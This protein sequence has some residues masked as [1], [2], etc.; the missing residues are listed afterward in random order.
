MGNGRFNHV[1]NS[2]KPVLLD[3]YADW[4]TPCKLQEPVLK[5]L[6][7]D[8]KDAVR[9]LKVDVNKN[10]LIATRYNIRSIPTIMIFK[11][12]S[13][14]WTGRGLKSKDELIQVLKKI[15]V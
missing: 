15:N 12:G 11:N 14:A 6:K 9:I 3:F 1:I 7:N 13:V 4:C 10:P 8:L 5:E 2:P